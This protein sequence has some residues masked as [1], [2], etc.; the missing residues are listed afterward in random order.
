MLLVTQ[1]NKC[2]NQ[3]LRTEFFNNIPL[4]RIKMRF[5]PVELML[6]IVIDSKVQT[7]TTAALFKYLQFDIGRAYDYKSYE[8][9]EE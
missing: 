8:K 7:N 5:K 9:Y 6:R 1:E 4:K 2:K 3:D